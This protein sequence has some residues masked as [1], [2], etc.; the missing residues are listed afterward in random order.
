MAGCSSATSTKTARSGK[1][2]TPAAAALVAPVG[3]NRN[4]EG[5]NPCR[6]CGGTG[7]V[8]YR[9]E[10]KDGE[11]EEAYRLCPRGHAPRYCMGYSGGCLCPRPASVRWGLGYYCK[12]HSA[13]IHDGRDHDRRRPP[14]SPPKGSGR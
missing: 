13:F 2:P 3:G 14:A 8:L 12:E 7:W 6:E 11:F 4:F 9:S 5:D 1:P 10:A